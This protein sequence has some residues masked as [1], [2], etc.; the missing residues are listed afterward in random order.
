MNSNDHMSTSKES[1]SFLTNKK[2]PLNQTAFQ[3]RRN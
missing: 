3:S 2:L 1:R